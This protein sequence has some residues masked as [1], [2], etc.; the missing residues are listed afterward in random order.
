M[1]VEGGAKL[2]TIWAAYVLLSDI[3]VDTFNRQ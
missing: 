1:H 2:C 3:K